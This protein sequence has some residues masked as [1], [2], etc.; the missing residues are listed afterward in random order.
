MLLMLLPL[1]VIG[2]FALQDPLGGTGDLG[3]TLPY[4]TEKRQEMHYEEVRQYFNAHQ[5]D[6]ETLRKLIQEAAK[7]S[8][9]AL[10]GK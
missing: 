4:T 3:A 8:I 9:F 2:Y 7:N 1:F 5:A 10:F 6:F